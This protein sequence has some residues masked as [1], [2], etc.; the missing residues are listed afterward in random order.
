M[1]YNHS[2]IQEFYKTHFN[3]D[4]TNDQ[5]AEDLG[6]DIDEVEEIVKGL[7]NKGIISK[8]IGGIKRLF[9]PEKRIEMV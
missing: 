9:N 5:I 8:I 4:I 3:Q 7:K 2:M 1:G 6:L